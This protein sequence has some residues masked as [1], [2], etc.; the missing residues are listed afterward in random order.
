MK[1]SKSLNKANW[2]VSH[3]MNKRGQI[4]ISALIIILVATVGVIGVLSQSKHIYVGDAKNKQVFDYYLCP[5][6]V[7]KIPQQNQIIFDNLDK[8]KEQKYN[9]F[10]GCV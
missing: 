4:E 9:L 3:P 8:A 7:N 6:K 5:E 1:K 2:K 10:Q